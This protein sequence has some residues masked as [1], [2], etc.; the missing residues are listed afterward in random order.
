MKENSKGGNVMGNT[1]ESVYEKVV[2]IVIDELGVE[3]LEIKKDSKFIDD[4]GADS[5][6]VIEM[7]MAIEDKFDI[8]IPD[9]HLENITTMD[10]TVKYILEKKK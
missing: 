6:A 1:Y 4:L 9:E 2:K 5:L 7:I 8:E 3:G 10:Q